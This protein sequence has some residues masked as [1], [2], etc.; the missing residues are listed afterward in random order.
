NPGGGGGGGLPPRPAAQARR[1]SPQ[2]ISGKMKGR[3]P[4]D[5]P[6]RA[7]AS[8]GLPVG[9]RAGRGAPVRV[10][11]GGAGMAVDDQA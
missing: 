5:R 7:Q 9:T 10:M 6:A 11:G 4:R 8:A 3:P 2:S 1:D